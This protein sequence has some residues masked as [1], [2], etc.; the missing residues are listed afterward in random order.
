MFEGVKVTKKNID[1]LDIG[2][3]CRI[4]KFQEND[5]LELFKYMTKATTEYDKVISYSQFKTLYFA[6]DG[7]RQIQGYGCFYA[8]KDDDE[9]SIEEVDNYYNDLLTRLQE[10]EKPIEV[11]EAPIDLMIDDEYVLISRKKVYSHLKKLK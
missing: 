7:R 8:L 3:S 4:D 9:I 10:K 6:L 11:S 1:Q 2:Y 5:Y